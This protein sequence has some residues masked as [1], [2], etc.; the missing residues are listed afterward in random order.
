[1]S[2]KTK[3][4]HTGKHKVKRVP[5]AEYV[6]RAKISDAT[7]AKLDNGDITGF[8]EAILGRRNV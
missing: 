4:Q 1:M 6:D 7:W 2:V 5:D 8:L 3:K